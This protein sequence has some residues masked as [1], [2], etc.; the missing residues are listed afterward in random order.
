M[1]ASG[2]VNEGVL[3]AAREILA[4]IGESHAAFVL[5]DILQN[6]NINAV[7]VD[8]AMM[9]WDGSAVHTMIER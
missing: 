8:Q 9:D 7:L 1:L 6:K 5:S 3:Q 2:Y 4:S